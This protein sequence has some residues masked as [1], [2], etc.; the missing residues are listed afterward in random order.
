LNPEA[1]ME[2]SRALLVIREAA[3]LKTPGLVEATTRGVMEFAQKELGTPLK[4]G[5]VLV[6]ER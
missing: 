4:E 2:L 5:G 1:I 3:R 6:I